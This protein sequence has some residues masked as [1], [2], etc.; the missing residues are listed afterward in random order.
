MPKLACPA[1]PVLPLIK[2][3]DSNVQGVSVPFNFF[4]DGMSLS[5]SFA[6]FVASSKLSALVQ[7]T[8]VPSCTALDLPP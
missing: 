4:V 3:A 8:F 5:T 7:A 6:N 2:S 1:R